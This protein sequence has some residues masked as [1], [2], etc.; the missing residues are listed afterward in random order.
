MRAKLRVSNVEPFDGG[1]NLSFSAVCKSEGYPEE[2]VMKTTL[3]PGSRQ[4]LN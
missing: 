3:L 4:R 2:G 1:E